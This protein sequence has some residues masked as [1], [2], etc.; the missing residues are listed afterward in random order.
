MGM[1]QS[2]FNEHKLPLVIEPNGTGNS[3][4]DLLHYMAANKQALEQE[5]YKTG[6]ILFRGFD[7]GT[8]KDFE[9]IAQQVDN[10]MESGYY[11]TSPRNPVPGTRFVYTASE[12]PGYYPIPQ[13]CEMSYV[14]HPPVSLFFYC[15]VE[16]QY[17]GETPL[18]DFR[19][20][21]AQL[22]P[23]I[24]EV[25]DKKGLITVRNYSGLGKSN[26]LNLFELKKWNEIFNTTDKLE[27]E[28]QCKD[29]EMDFEWLSDG[30]LRITHNTPAAIEHPHTKEKVWFNH[31][32]VFHPNGASEEYKHIHQYQHRFKTLLW[33][34]FLNL[35]VKVKHATTA[36]I[37][38]S[39]NVLLGDGK[40]IPPSWVE[41]LEEVIWKN[42][43][44]FPWKKNDV[45]A[46]DNFSTAHGR[47][48]YEGPREILVCWSV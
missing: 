35:M 13:H 4:Q 37:D 45:V 21:Y 18:C 11:G 41:H 43:V 36:P 48:P 29:Q 6:A 10:R 27:V 31:I 28:R 16:P 3:K 32:Q 19:K 2:Y 20:V 23:K 34:T 40:E 25:F 8:P 9:D 30:G 44:I 46:I 47:L 26:K 15:H 17:G 38:Q 5:F 1:K 42:L 14:K 33:S 12:L 39:M 7:L 22:D 24:R